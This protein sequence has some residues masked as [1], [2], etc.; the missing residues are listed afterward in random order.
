MKDLSNF[1]S[2]ASQVTNRIPWGKREVTDDGEETR[3]YGASKSLDNCIPE[4][5]QIQNILDQVIEEIK[6]INKVIEGDPNPFQPFPEPPFNDPQPDGKKH[7]IDVNIISS[8]QLVQSIDGIQQKLK[9]L[10]EQKNMEN[11]P[12]NNI[13]IPQIQPTF[14]NQPNV[15]N[16]LP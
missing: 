6:R 1:D 14:V 8:W 10:I 13:Y 5:K 4:M 11:N 15:I 12:I 9:E 3:K 7:Q 16:N 2:E